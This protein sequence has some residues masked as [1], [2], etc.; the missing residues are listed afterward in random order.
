[1]YLNFLLYVARVMY[2]IIAR[3]AGLF[4]NPKQLCTCDGVSIWDEARKNKQLKI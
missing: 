1:M 4:E 3:S 2:G